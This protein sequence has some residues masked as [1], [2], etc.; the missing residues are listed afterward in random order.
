MSST[1]DRPTLDRP[2]RAVSA[3]GAKRI[4][5]YAAIDHRA[6]PASPTFRRSRNLALVSPASREDTSTTG[7]DVRPMSPLSPGLQNQLLRPRVIETFADRS[8]S[9]HESLTV[10]IPQFIP[11]D[12]V[13]LEEPVKEFYES[14]LLLYRNFG[15]DQNDDEPPSSR[16]LSD[17]MTSPD[18]RNPGSG[19]R[20]ASSALSP[21]ETSSFEAERK[22]A[23]R[24]RGSNPD[25]GNTYTGKS[26]M[27]QHRS[28]PATMTNF[29]FT[30]FAE[31]ATTSPEGE[32][33]IFE[34]IAPLA[35][36]SGNESSRSE[37]NSASPHHLNSRPG[38]RNSAPHGRHLGV[39]APNRKRSLRGSWSEYPSGAPRATTS[40][41]RRSFKGVS[42]V[43]MNQEFHRYTATRRHSVSWDGAC[44]C[45]EAT[46]GRHIG[47][48]S[49]DSVDSKVLLKQCAWCKRRPASFLCL[50]CGAGLCPSH[51][52]AHATDDGFNEC[53]LFV[54]MLD[55][56]T[57]Y[58]R[59]YWC[60]RCTSFT[61]KFTDPYCAL[62]DSLVN[63]RGTYLPQPATDIFM[64][65]Y[66]IKDNAKTSATHSDTLSTVTT[67]DG[68]PPVS[69][70]LIASAA[71]MQGWRSTQE[72]SE[73]VF[74]LS[75]SGMGFEPEIASRLLQF[76]TCSVF[77]VFDGHGGDAVAKIASHMVET[78]FA[79]ALKSVLWDA[80]QDAEPSNFDSAD[81][82]QALFQ[83]VFAAVFLAMDTA[84][85]DTEDG[86]EGFYG[87]VGCT[88]LI[89]AI[90]PTDIACGSLGDSRAC[91]YD[92][93]RAKCIP[94]S[95]DHTL[96]EEVEIVRA[97]LAGYSVIDGR[98]EGQLAV[99]RALGDFDFKQCGSKPPNEQAV[100]IEPCVVV[101]PRQSLALGEGQESVTAAKLPPM[102]S[103]SPKKP[104]GAG[105]A[106]ED[107]FVVLACD[108]IWDVLTNE[109]CCTLLNE[110]FQQQRR[111]R[112]LETYQQ[113][114]TGGERAGT[115]GFAPSSPSQR[116]ESSPKTDDNVP[117]RSRPG[118]LR[119]GQHHPA[120]NVLLFAN[121]FND[122]VAN[123]ICAVLKRSLALEKDEDNALGLD[124]MSLI[125]ARLV[126]TI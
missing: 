39:S 30:A 119:G 7:T 14:E 1:P 27:R 63:S 85:Q 24:R 51:V 69:M 79:A 73:V 47:K 65:H 98:L 93:H 52:H 6:Q 109:N 60:E 19:S 87:T 122:I 33:P 67:A 41:V 59:I 34:V 18:T 38:S 49:S 74:Y 84:I 5:K 29:S 2:V 106:P 12:G 28:P 83:K 81:R 88:A 103:A 114:I 124:N 45:D 21:T 66:Q 104:S 42:L 101:V 32:A 120:T 86:Q 91:L 113:A 116:A 8:L 56:T 40:S 50:H 31:P 55:I 77:C 108:G 13:D 118:S 35:A 20:R 125:V 111:D 11:E 17:G 72:D 48:I 15:V 89:V 3:A 102:K 68:G 105:T 26:P 76:E 16:R 71:S 97:R 123:S 80:A 44:E 61:Y 70:K 82:R 100:S 4:M 25:E 121:T 94:L 22:S 117:R 62:A 99:P 78:H 23:L 9:M 54:N 96:D 126:T 110:S 115:L 37:S 58:D 10:S 95:Y 107:W 92:A 90:T 36:T 75:L 64:R 112:Q 53:V 57:S 43:D 46:I